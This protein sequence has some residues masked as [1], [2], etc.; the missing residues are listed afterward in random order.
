M[1]YG[2]NA[3]KSKYDLQ[4]LV[5]EIETKADIDSPELT[6]TPK[7]PTARNSSNDTQL[8]TTAFV[9]NAIK[10]YLK[11]VYPVNSVYITTTNTNPSGIIG[12]TWTLLSSKVAVSENIYGNGKTLGLCQGSNTYGLYATNDSYN[13]VKEIGPAAGRLGYTANATDV[14]DDLGSVP[15]H[16]MVG[17]LTKALAG[18]TPSNTGLVTDTITIYIWK[19]TAL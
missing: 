8:A 14:G 15:G 13:G 9:K 2:F 17:V 19:R 5:D 7:A 3:D 18:N 6:G 11:T 1:P 10:E 4:D 16:T 12:G